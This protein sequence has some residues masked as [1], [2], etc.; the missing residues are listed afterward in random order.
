MMIKKEMPRKP[1]YD[2]TNVFRNSE[3]PD[4][5]IKNVNDD[6]MDG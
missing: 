3:Q 1:P 5:S 4:V 2:E 6:F